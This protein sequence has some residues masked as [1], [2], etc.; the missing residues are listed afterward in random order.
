[1][2]CQPSRFAVLTIAAMLEPPPE[3]KI[4][5]FFIPGLIL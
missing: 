5:M 3:I 1:L 4:T 2:S